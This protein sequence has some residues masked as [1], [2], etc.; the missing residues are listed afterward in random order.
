MRKTDIPDAPNMNYAN[1]QRIK[2]QHVQTPFGMIAVDSTVRVPKLSASKRT[3]KIWFSRFVDIRLD[4][5]R[6]VLS[7]VNKMYYIDTLNRWKEL[8]FKTNGK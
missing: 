7:F 3:W 2:I 1:S 6:S 5:S 8:A 4:D